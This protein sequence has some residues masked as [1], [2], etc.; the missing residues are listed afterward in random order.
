MTH[1]LQNR[2]GFAPFLAPESMPE[3]ILTEK[4]STFW[5]LQAGGWAAYAV[6]RLLSG[7]AFGNQLGSLMPTVVAATTG[8]CL[9]LIMASIFRRLIERGGWAL[10]GVAILTIAVAA[11]VFALLDMWAYARFVNNAV[12]PL[13]ADFLGWALYDVYV[14]TSWTGLY[15][16]I[17]YYMA[18]QSQKRRMLSLSAQAQAAQL[19]MLRYQL[20]P[21]FL[22]NTLN[23]IS[24]LV[25]LKDT[26]RA[27]AMLTSLSS[28]LRYTLANDAAT[29][30][31]LVK[32]IET[33]KLYLDIERLRFEDRLRVHFDIDPA[34]A[35]VE[36]PSLLLQPLVENA[37]KYG[38]A[39]R[40]EGADITVKAYVD[41]GRM[42]LE[43]AD[44]GPGLDGTTTKPGSIGLPNTRERLQQVY[45]PDH[46]I[47][48]RANMP[49][50]LAVV[51]NIPVRNPGLTAPDITLKEPL[52]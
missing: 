13:A 52:K 25:L 31:P 37:I 6:L 12:Q 30:V 10:W 9:T 38:V 18:V 36:V 26:E 41:A 32:E 34:A 5:V 21:H 46:S 16:G 24:T 22:F 23:S 11:S 40:E 45:G 33:L 28:F 39:P 1:I 44:T 35:L 8:F 29:S 17:N 50:G 19:K 14:L 47:K 49:R 4:S 48:I 7:E 42:Q 2:F 20:N 51:I 3:A 43:V 15:F 27:N